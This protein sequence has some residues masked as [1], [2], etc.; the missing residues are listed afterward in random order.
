VDRLGRE[1]I[2][3]GVRLTSS[4]QGWVEIFISVWRHFK[5]ISKIIDPNIPVAPV[6]RIVESFIGDK[7]NDEDIFSISELSS[8][9]FVF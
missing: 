9:T 8:R 4:T 6:R 3:E 1:R 7:S 5:I 2:F